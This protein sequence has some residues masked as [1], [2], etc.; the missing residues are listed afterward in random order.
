MRV[1]PGSYSYICTS[2]GISTLAVQSIHR[3]ASANVINQAC[4]S[5][6]VGGYVKL[7]ADV[8]SSQSFALSSSP[9]DR[10][11]ALLRR[12]GSFAVRSHVVVNVSRFAV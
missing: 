10:R 7:V 9:S 3:S 8:R 12:R 11:V 4:S 2:Y 5:T 6:G 1:N